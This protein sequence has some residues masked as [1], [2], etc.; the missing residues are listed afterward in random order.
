MSPQAARP[1]SI[2]PIL[3]L[4]SPDWKDYE[5]LDSGNGMKLERYGKVRLA[6]PEPEAMWRPSLP[7]KEWKNIH[8]RFVITSEEHGGHWERYQ[9]LPAQWVL[10]YKDLRFRLQTTASRHVGV[11]PEQAAQWDWITAR[12]RAAGRPLKV[13]NLFGYTGV[14]SVAAA[15]AGAAV[16]HVDASRKVVH[17][18][19]ENRQLS[20]LSENAIR[21]IV[22]DAIKYVQREGRR[23]S[24]YDG[25]ILDP[26]KFG[27]GPKGEI[28]EFYKFL[29]DLLQSCRQVMAPEADF[30]VLTAYAVK[31]SALTLHYAVEDATAGL[32]GETQSGEVV[33]IEKSAGRALSLAVFARWS[34]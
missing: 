32:G 4:D 5:L 8:A 21:W 33:L 10:G 23:G 3:T 9:D 15:R 6:R 26:P 30:M 11:F 14:A 16:T 22:D 34:K 12:V 28:W 25:I 31:A 2:P 27:R 20:G 17:W 1:H 19:G 7:E 29:P 13:L 24:T 18:A